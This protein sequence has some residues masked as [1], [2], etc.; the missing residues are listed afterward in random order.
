[1][2]YDEY[3]NEIRKEF[4][5]KTTQFINAEN[6]LTASATGFIDKS[7]IDNYRNAKRDWQTIA[8]TYNTFLD[9]IRSRDVNPNE[10]M[11]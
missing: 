9:Y 1:M 4:A 3:Y 5:L 8:N 6:S 11:I 2:T 7:E 10:E